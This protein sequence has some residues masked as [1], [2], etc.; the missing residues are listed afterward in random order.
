M[1]KI[2]TLRTMLDTYLVKAPLPSSFPSQLIW[3]TVPYRTHAAY[4]GINKNA[5]RGKG[6]ERAL[7]TLS[8][9]SLKFRSEFI[10]AASQ[11]DKNLHRILI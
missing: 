3:N 7:D 8:S 1:V 11:I 9:L 2:N 6:I 4:N 10:C 5:Y